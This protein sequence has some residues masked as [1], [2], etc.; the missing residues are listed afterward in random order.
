VNKPHLTRAS[1]YFGISLILIA[2]FILSRPIYITREQLEES[3]L[4]ASGKWVLQIVLAIVLLKR[5]RLSFIHALGRI[6]LLS[7]IFFLPFIVSSW[8]EINNDPLFFIA[9]MA[10]AGFITIY[11]YY[12]E[13]K[14]LNL[15]MGWWYFWV[16]SNALSVALQVTVVFRLA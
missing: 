10:I 7:S 16:F 4:V 6:C 8:L 13:I 15:S 5:R 1:I 2:V 11:R 12:L 9:S 14:R 3:I